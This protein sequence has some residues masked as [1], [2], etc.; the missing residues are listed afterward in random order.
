MKTNDKIKKIYDV[1]DS[2]LGEDIV[3]LNVNGVSTITDYFI[4][5][6]AKSERQVNALQDAVD[7]E[8]TKLNVEARAIEG[9]ITSRWILMDYGDVVVHIFK[10]EEREFYNLERLWKDAVFVDVK[11]L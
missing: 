2:K 11:E 7:D 10:D 9:R 6:S 1:L 5:V 4:I 8:M 3:I